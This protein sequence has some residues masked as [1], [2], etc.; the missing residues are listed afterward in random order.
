[1]N[2]LAFSGMLTIADFFNAQSCT[3]KTSKRILPLPLTCET[4]YGLIF[5][6]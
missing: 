6:L 3:P 5:V 2:Q 1:V 4:V